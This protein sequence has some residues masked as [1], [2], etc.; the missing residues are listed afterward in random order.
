LR[1]HTPRQPEGQSGDRPACRRSVRLWSKRARVR[2]PSTHLDKPNQT[3]AA[4]VLTCEID[5]AESLLPE[6]RVAAYGFVASRA[7][8]S[9]DEGS[10][11]ECTG[12]TERRA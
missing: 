5:A 12:W 2:I 8:D 6:L 7:G 3:P 11:G 9:R 10:S 4:V 1:H